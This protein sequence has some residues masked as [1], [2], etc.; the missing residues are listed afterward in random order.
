MVHEAEWDESTDLARWSHLLAGVKGLNSL[1]TLN[2]TIIQTRGLP[3]RI[4]VRPAIRISDKE[5]FPSLIS[6]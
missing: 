4:N 6:S 2:L 5:N 1:S 3:R